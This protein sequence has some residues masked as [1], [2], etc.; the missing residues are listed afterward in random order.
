MLFSA[1]C[2]CAMLG[3]GLFGHADRTMTPYGWSGGIGGYFGGGG[4]G[5]G[6]GGVWHSTLAIPLKLKRMT[7]QTLQGAPPGCDIHEKPHALRRLGARALWS[8]LGLSSMV[9]ARDLLLLL[10]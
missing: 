1:H 4:R 9:D 8:V 10:L 3:S 2:C 5:G 7:S 6:D